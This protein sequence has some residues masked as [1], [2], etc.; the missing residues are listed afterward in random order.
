MRSV[1]CV[2]TLDS[3]LYLTCCYLGVSL[4]DCKSLVQGGAQHCNEHA[5]GILGAAGAAAAVFFGV[6]AIQENPAT[7]LEERTMESQ[8]PGPLAR[9]NAVL[10]FGSTGKMGRLLVQQV[11]SLPYHRPQRNCACNAHHQTI[12]ELM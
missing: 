7:T 8:I 6:K 1:A 3:H 4:H 2:H 9:E 11:N 12:F 5:A 10:V